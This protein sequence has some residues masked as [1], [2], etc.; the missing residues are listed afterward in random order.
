MLTILI[1]ANFLTSLDDP[2]HFMDLLLKYS[3]YERSFEGSLEAANGKE[4][5]S[6]FTVFESHQG[7]II[8]KALPGMVP[9]Y[10]WEH[11]L[12]VDSIPDYSMSHFS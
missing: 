8:H 7:N 6:L 9:Q 11:L 5:S 2:H 12:Q 1:T 3:L 10:L 4:C